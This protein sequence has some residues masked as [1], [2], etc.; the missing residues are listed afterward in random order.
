MWTSLR[1]RRGI[2]LPTI[3]LVVIPQGIYLIIQQKRKFIRWI[4][5]AHKIGKSKWNQLGKY[6]LKDTLENQETGSRMRF[7]QKQFGAPPPPPPKKSLYCHCVLNHLLKIQSPKKYFETVQLAKPQPYA[8]P[9][10]E[11]DRKKRGKR[12]HPLPQ[13]SNWIIKYIK[14]L[15]NGP[16]FYFHTKVESF[17]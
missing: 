4:S 1:W 12:N 11:Q 5:D 6:T 16:L 2:I 7:I 3:G 17:T 8:N 10:P 13:A 15:N 9:L 14:I